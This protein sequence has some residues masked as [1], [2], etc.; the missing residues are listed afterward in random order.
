MGTMLPSCD[1]LLIVRTS[2]LHILREDTKHC[3]RRICYW[4]SIGAG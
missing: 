1:M 3:K 2:L 4:K